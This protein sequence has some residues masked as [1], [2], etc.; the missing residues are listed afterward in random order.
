M[1]KIHKY[2]PENFSEVFDVI[3]DGARAYKGIIPQDRWHE[4]Y[5]TE[6]ELLAQVNEGVEF[7]LYTDDNMIK[8]V[9]GIQPREKVTL[10]R[11][12]YVRTSARNKGIGSRLLTH[13]LAKITTPVLIG[14]WTDAR[15]AIDFYKKHGFRLLPAEEKNRLLRK[16]WNIPGRQIETSVVLAGPTWNQKLIQTEL[17]SR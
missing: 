3:N 10:I 11:H 15:W 1:P 16:Y 13:L 9:M 4:P 7:W 2:L 6:E 5:M 12:A 17:H 14:T 8:G